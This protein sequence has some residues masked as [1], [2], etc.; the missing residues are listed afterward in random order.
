MTDERQIDEYLST[1]RNYLGPM[2]LDEREEIVR[3]IQ[4]HIRDAVEECGNDAATVLQRLGSPED[5]AAQYRDGL[6]VRRASRSFSPVLLLRASLRVASKGIFGLLVFFCG[7]FGYAFG[8][9]L[10]LTAVAKCILPRNTGVWVTGGHL[11][12][13]GVLFPPPQA[14]AHEIL[15]WWYIPVALAIG[16]VLVVLTTLAIRGFLRISHRL[17]SGLRAP[18]RLEQASA[19]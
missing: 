15:G 16:C 10:I 6:L 1:L 8:G 14:P 3:E 2:T 13:S 5:L 17:Q 11:S 7:L 9:G 12:N 18:V 4:A 19:R